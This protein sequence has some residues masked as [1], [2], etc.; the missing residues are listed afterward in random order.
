MPLLSNYNVSAKAF[1]SSNIIRTDTNGLCI[2]I[3]YLTRAN[4]HLELWF[5]IWVP[6][7]ISANLESL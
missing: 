7:M 6:N 1:N 4:C 5:D 2:D 3:K